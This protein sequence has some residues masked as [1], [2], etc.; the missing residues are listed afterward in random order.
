M[1]NLFNEL[2]SDLPFVDTDILGIFTLIFG[3]FLV[4]SVLWLLKRL[5]GG[6]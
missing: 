1:Y 2:F 3:L 5:F 6:K 4:D